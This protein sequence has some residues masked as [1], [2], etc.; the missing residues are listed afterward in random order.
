[1]DLIWH[2]TDIHGLKGIISNTSLWATDIEFLNDSEEYKI[3]LQTIKKS[4]HDTISQYYSFDKTK[5]LPVHKEIIQALNIVTQFPVNP[6]D[7]LKYLQTIIDKSSIAL[8]STLN[9][10]EEN[11]NNRHTY[12]TSFTNSRDNLRQWMAYGKPNMSYSIGFKKDYFLNNYKFKTPTLKSSDFVHGLIDVNYRKQKEDCILSQ[13][14]KE[15]L[16]PLQLIP[17]IMNGN[18][19]KG[20][21]KYVTSIMLTSCAT[22][23]YLFREENETRLV[24]QPR[25]P[26]IHYEAEQ[27]RNNG[28]VLIPYIDLKFDPQ[29][30]K[31]IIIG[32]TT[33]PELAEKGL[34]RFLKSNNMEHCKV[35]HSECPL[36]VII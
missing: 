35:T 15:S 26:D 27:Y 8:N 34:L 24:L 33:H 10:L 23:S 17:A 9:M 25:K 30:I 7:E 13:S 1:M 2:H 6:K 5:E 16:A 14:I 12:T 36:R 31:E 21:S 29:E 11:L 19:I 3:G 32:P 20:L 28:G 4:I 22:K 18:F